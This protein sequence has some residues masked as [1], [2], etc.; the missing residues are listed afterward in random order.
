M[1]WKLAKENKNMNKSYGIIRDN[2]GNVLSN[3]MQHS[4]TY[5][6]DIDS[7]VEKT[8]E[9]K[10][11]DPLLKPT[12]LVYPSTSLPSSLS[13]FSLLISYQQLLF[14]ALL[15]PSPVGSLTLR[16]LSLLPTSNQLYKDIL[17]IDENVNDNKM[18]NISNLKDV[19]ITMGCGI[20]DNDEKKWKR[21]FPYNNFQ[22]LNYSL[23]ILEMFIEKTCEKR[24]KEEEK[25][26]NEKEE[27]KIVEKQEK[28]QDDT[29]TK[30]NECIGRTIE[31]ETLDEKKE[32]ITVEEAKI[33]TESSSGTS[34]TRFPE[35]DETL[36]QV[37]VCW[38]VRFLL[39]GGL[40]QL[41]SILFVI[42]FVDKPEQLSTGD[43]KK[44]NNNSNKEYISSP[45]F[46]DDFSP[47]VEG[48]LKS[49]GSFIG[50]RVSELLCILKILKEFVFN[51]DLIKQI[52]KTPKNIPN[53][54]YSNP[55]L[56]ILLLQISKTYYS[57]NV[58]GDSADIC[59][60]VS[61]TVF[62]RLLYLLS[63]FSVDPAHNCFEV[64]ISSLPDHQNVFEWFPIMK[65][66]A[67]SILEKRRSKKSGL[68]RHLVSLFKQRRLSKCTCGDKILMMG[69]DYDDY[70]RDINGES[71][72]EELVRSNSIGNVKLDLE[73]KNCAEVCDLVVDMLKC[74]VKCEERNSFE[75]L[76][77]DGFFPV[78]RSLLLCSVTEKRRNSFGDLLWAIC[79]EMIYISKRKII[80]NESSDVSESSSLQEKNYKDK[81]ASR[82]ILYERLPLF[83]LRDNLLDFYDDVDKKNPSFFLISYFQFLRKF[84]ESGTTDIVDES[85]VVEYSESDINQKYPCFY[86]TYVH[87]LPQYINS[88]DLCYVLSFIL[89]KRTSTELRYKQQESDLVLCNILSLL[90]GLVQKADSSLKGLLGCEYCDLENEKERGF[91]LIRHVFHYMLFDIGEFKAEEERKDNV[92]EKEIR[93]VDEFDEVWDRTLDH[94]TGALVMKHRPQNIV[95]LK[96]ALS[97]PFCKKSETRKEALDLLSLLCKDCPQNIIRVTLL[98]ALLQDR[99]KYRVI[100]EF[101]YDARYELEGNSLLVCFFLINDV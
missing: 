81:L 55:V 96:N 44:L 56:N 46:D 50:I 25:K 63:I 80:S 39:S 15:L 20:S 87:F 79:N 13:P 97:F 22:S 47:S 4:V 19:D 92:R 74:L 51:D 35:V 45:S 75:V 18:M 58:D 8:E 91:D 2:K 14:D 1:L 83:S 23:R 11:S 69:K 5:H 34:K 86:R 21:I 61:K 59:N 90:N 62:W 73:S 28:I 85:S 36:P 76:A 9:K 67:D 57:K 16:I 93:D 12:S 101:D 27:K 100:K 77:S 70:F 64:F 72:D 10:S 98:M 42:D 40:M 49:T 71:M 37:D 65:P 94:S 66:W 53:I 30:E 88:G 84:I 32:R 48:K 52:S 99:Q 26:S 24:G 6:L 89:M 68:I 17:C 3:E 29:N 54:L 43:F 82:L 31:K 38:R 95:P 33:I 7:F 60:R 41:L 78:M